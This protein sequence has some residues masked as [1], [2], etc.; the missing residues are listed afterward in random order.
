MDQDTR[1]GYHR[2]LLKISGEAL[3]GPQSFGIDSATLKFIAGEIRTV[4]A[5]G[6]QLGVVIGGGNF[7]RGMSVAA[8]DMERVSADYIGMLA[9]VMNAI[10]LHQ[11]LEAGGVPSRIQSA[12][13]VTSIVE[14]YVR[15][16]ALKHMECGR[17]VVFAAGTGNPLFTT[18]T[19]ASL[20][21]IEI[22][23]QLMIKATKVDG[24][25]NDDPVKNPTAVRYNQLTY[26]QVLAENLQVM[27]ATAIT[28]C[29]DH[30]MPVQVL[31]INRPGSLLRAVR[32][33]PEGTFI[34]GGLV[35]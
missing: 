5:T 7:F 14:S 35:R 34:D 10:A 17:V 23:A 30:A 22:D 4:V 31:N 9:T 16:R 13:A 32:G 18:D 1:T 25:Y 27:D 3:A 20:R 29:R 11:S 33:C 12:I 28:L 24:V 6:V 15:A 2:I 21:A 8:T 19:A 26:D